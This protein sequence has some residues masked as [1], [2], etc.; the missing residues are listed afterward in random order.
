MCRATLNLKSGVKNDGV[1][2]IGRDVLPSSTF[3]AAFPRNVW[4]SYAS[5][6]DNV[7]CEN[8][9]TTLFEFLP[10]DNEIAAFDD[11]RFCLIMITMRQFCPLIRRVSPR[12]QPVDADEVKKYKL[13]LRWQGSHYLSELEVVDDSE[14]CSILSTHVVG[15]D[16][17]QEMMS[18]TVHGVSVAGSVGR[19]ARLRPA[20]DGMIVGV[21]D[22]RGPMLTEVFH[23]KLGGSVRNSREDN[24]L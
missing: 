10:D 3:T 23:C 24:D 15:K 1:L 11:D 5:W 18:P 22:A 13:Q 9:L 17:L 8:L 19:T 14:N 4:H 16:F 21:F 12:R 20:H 6:L 2:A 7:T